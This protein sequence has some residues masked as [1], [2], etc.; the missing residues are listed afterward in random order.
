METNVLTVKVVSTTKNELP[1]YQTEG[2][3]AMD[4]RADLTNMNSDDRMRCSLGY[5]PK[6]CKMGDQ[7]YSMFYVSNE[8]DEESED[9]LVMMIPPHCRANIKTGLFIEVPKGYKMSMDPRSGLSSKLG[10]TLVNGRGKIDSDYRGEIKILVINTSDEPLLVYNGDR[11][12]QIELEKVNKFKWQKV[13]KLSETNR[14]SG[15]LGH[16]GTNK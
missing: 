10:L 13:E 4:L 16:T 2:S 11:L 5:M 9:K 8:L 15:G 1:S 12:C 3:A 7:N 14:G 6:D